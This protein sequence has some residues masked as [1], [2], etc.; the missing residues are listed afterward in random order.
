M[1]PII[2]GRITGVLPCSLLKHLP[3][4]PGARGDTRAR[5][6]GRGGGQ[7][8]CEC[9][10]SLLLHARID[11]DSL[12]ALKDVTYAFF[13][14]QGW[15][16]PYQVTP[17]SRPSEDVCVHTSSFPHVDHHARLPRPPRSSPAFLR[18]CS[19]CSLYLPSTAA[20]RDS[21]LW[22]SEDLM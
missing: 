1:E 3:T 12:L 7:V 14:P 16:S 11:I 8:M 15:Y 4:S 22:S 2:E 10:S 17:H 13:F 6:R 21:K 19:P 9:A 20:H 5:M 18:L